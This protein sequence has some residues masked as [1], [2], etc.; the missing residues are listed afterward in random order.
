M[1]NFYLI[2]FYCKNNLILE[3]WRG[4]CKFKED[5]LVYV[6]VIDKNFGFVFVFIDRVG[7]EIL[8]YFNDMKFYVK[9]IE[10]YWIFRCY[11]VIEIREKFVNSYFSFFCFNLFK[12]FWL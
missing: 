11:M 8:K 2:L 1:E 5:F 10:Y 7:N 6:I 9:V 4:L 12:F 3:E